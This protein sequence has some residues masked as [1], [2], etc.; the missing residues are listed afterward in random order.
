[1]MALRSLF[2]QTQGTF[3]VVVLTIGWGCTHL[4][5]SMRAVE[6]AAGPTPSELGSAG[7]TTATEATLVVLRASISAPDEP[8]QVWADETYLGTVIPKSYFEVKL[9][10]G[11][12]LLW[13]DAE[14]T[15]AL[16]ARL[17]AGQTY[18][19][20]VVPNLGHRKPR[21]DLLALRRDDDL[22][23]GQSTWR[24]QLQPLARNE[25]VEAPVPRGP[26]S[27]AERNE[28]AQR[29]FSQYGNEEK[30]ARTLVPTDGI[31]ASDALE[32]SAQADSATN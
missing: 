28:H 8:F 20:E 31:S 11:A 22:V 27:V 17:I 13:A 21:C 16:L 3:L 29:I 18:F 5:P 2:G 10:A 25:R 19:V 14:N 32:P 26:W 9:P 6:P 12:H 4:P 24:G 15:P 7:A 1:M 23:A 30:T